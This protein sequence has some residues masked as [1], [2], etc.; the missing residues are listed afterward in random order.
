MFKNFSIVSFYQT[1]FVYCHDYFK[2]F[3]IQILW[4]KWSLYY[5]VLHFLHV[6]LAAI[7]SFTDQSLL[8]KKSLMV[9]YENYVAFELSL[10]N[11]QKAGE[12][13]RNLVETEQNFVEAWVLLVLLYMKYS[14][15]D[16]VVKIAEE[17]IHKCEHDVVIVYFYSTWLLQQVGILFS[18]I[19]TNDATVFSLISFICVI[20][21]PVL[22]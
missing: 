22:H 6:I 12:F 15:I 7:E 10:C 2:N 1:S 11:I 17:A 20:V 3:L 13:L 18:T 21:K 19:T 4:Y 8:A 14:P 5:T 9:L 16:T